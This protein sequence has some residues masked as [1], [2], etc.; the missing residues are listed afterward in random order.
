LRSARDNLA[1][2]RRV[3]W[4]LRP[5]PLAERSCWRHST[6]WPRLAEETGMRVGAVAMGAVRPLDAEAEV[7]LLRIAQEALANVRKHAAATEATVT[8]SY[9]DD[10]VLLD[11]ADDGSGFDPTGAQLTAPFPTR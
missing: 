11:V 8:L 3:V 5:R 10:G 9:L 7:A 1:E 6:S 2:S 4:A